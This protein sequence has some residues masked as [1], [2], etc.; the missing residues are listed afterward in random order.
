MQ[1][2]FRAIGFLNIC[3]FLASPIVAPAQDGGDIDGIRERL[4]GQHQLITY[5]D[6]GPLYGTFYFLHVHFCASGTYFTMA[7]SHRT[8]VLNNHE[9]RQWQDYGRWDLV[10]LQGHTVLRYI[11]SAGKGGDIVPLTLL[12]DGRLWVREGVTVIPRGRAL[13]K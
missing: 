13:C 5:R 7:E 6:G 11:S 8:T 4:A 3:F 9:D 2:A 1:N 10:S 12:P